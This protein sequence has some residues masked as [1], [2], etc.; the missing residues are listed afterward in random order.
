MSRFRSFLKYQAPALL[1]CIA[2]YAL[3]AV[4]LVSRMKIPLR[5]DKLVHG[6]LYFVLCLLVWRAFHYQ[7]RFSFLKNRALL[8]AFLFS[9][10]YGLIDEIHQIF[11]PGRTPDIYDVVAD[12]TGAFL[13][14]LFFWWRRRDESRNAVQNAFDKG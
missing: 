7:S 11:V 13:A 4:P 9:C 3:S 8:S 10:L 1:W 2:I 5:A 14:M 12:G 6:V